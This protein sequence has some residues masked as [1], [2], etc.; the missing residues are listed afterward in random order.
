MRKSTVSNA[1][2]GIAGLIVFLVG[3]WSLAVAGALFL[4]LT[5]VPHERLADSWYWIIGAS[6][7]ALGICL[8]VRAPVILF[9][10]AALIHAP[11]VGGL[12]G[13][14]LLGEVTSGRGGSV[15][16]HWSGPRT[17]EFIAF[18]VI[19]FF[20]WFLS[21]LFLGYCIIREAGFPSDAIGRTALLFSIGLL[22]VSL[23]YV[24]MLAPHT[25]IGP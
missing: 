10:W 18:F 14:L 19:T 11:I 17:P 16:I 5:T 9:K 1:V 3:I 23:A 25:T 15:A 12:L 6:C 8:L 24:W 4:H 13:L 2:L 20:L 21:P 22:I 7:L